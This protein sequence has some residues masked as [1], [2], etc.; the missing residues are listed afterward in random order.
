MIDE[1]SL[2]LAPV[3]VAQLLPLVEAMRA[4]GTTV[5]LVEQSVNVALDVADTAVLHGEGRDP[6]PRPDRGAARPPRRAPLGLPRGRDAAGLSGKRRP[7]RRSP[8]PTTASRSKR[9][10]RCS[11]TSSRVGRL[12]RHPRRRRR[13]DRGRTGRD[14][15]HHRAQRRGQDDAVRPHLRLRPRRRRR[16]APRRRRHHRRGPAARARAG[17]GRSFQDA[18]LFPSLTVAEAIAVACERWIDVRDP[19]RAALH[20]PAAFDSER[21]VRTRVDEL[22]DLLGLGAFRSKFVRELSTGIPPGRR[23]RLPARPP[24]RR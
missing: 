21:Q 20:L 5:I 13:V 14:R 9:G 11:S 17:L 16:C 6:L 18:R 10:R 23:P 4:D 8:A 22:I 3:V 12:R 19:S 2:G 1:L 15:R 7:R 24:A